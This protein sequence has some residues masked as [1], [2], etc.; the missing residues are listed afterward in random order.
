MDFELF[1]CPSRKRRPF[2]LDYIVPLDIM[3][4]SRVTPGQQRMSRLDELTELSKVFLTAEAYDGSFNFYWFWEFSPRGW[5]GNA[6]PGWTIPHHGLTTTNTG[7]ADGHV[8]P[9]SYNGEVFM[10]EGPT[11]PS[12]NWLQWNG[13]SPR[14]DQGN[15]YWQRSQL[16]LK[17]ATW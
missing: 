8:G 2:S 5:W 9:H 12:V 6:R 14:I 11:N 13:F 3:G 4:Y 16:G 1:H 7:Y 10:G 17:N 15:N